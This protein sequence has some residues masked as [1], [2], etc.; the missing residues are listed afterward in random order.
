MISFE[1]CVWVSSET[2]S[3]FVG[4]D[5]DK[6]CVLWVLSVTSIGDKL[7]VYEF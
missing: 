4:F 6:F 5:G 7:C 3:V 1:F 2:N